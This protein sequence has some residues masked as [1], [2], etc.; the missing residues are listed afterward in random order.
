MINRGYIFNN[1][2]YLED[3]NGYVCDCCDPKTRRRVAVPS[4]ADGGSALDNQLI[5]A[6]PQLISG[7]SAENSE[8]EINYMQEVMIL[9]FVNFI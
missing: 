6:S 1:M 2:I 8:A 9:F 7:S 5:D 3:E 4:A